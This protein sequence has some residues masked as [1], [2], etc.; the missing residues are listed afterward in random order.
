MK[1]SAKWR[2]KLL[3]AALTVVAGLMVVPAGAFE[4]E[5][6]GNATF[7]PENPTPEVAA[8]YKKGV[9]WLSRRES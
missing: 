3:G 7:S 6:L 8:V 2:R 5:I 4:L 1:N 9:G